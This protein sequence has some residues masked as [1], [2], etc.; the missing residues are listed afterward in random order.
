M[1]LLQP[2]YVS[3]RKVYISCRGEDSYI[4]ADVLIWDGQENEDSFK[5]GIYEFPFNFTIPER[6]PPSFE[7]DHGKIQFFCKA[8]V[9]RPW[10]IDNKAEI[11]FIVK[12]QFDLN[13]IPGLGNKVVGAI[14]E[15]LG[16]IFFK[17][18]KVDAK[19]KIC[20]TSGPKLGLVSK[21]LAPWDHGFMGTARVWISSGTTEACPTH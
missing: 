4:N 16:A 17:H 7:G 19:V 11:R 14:D 2:G 1:G 12:P 9:D 5:P 20:L 3:I 10:H 15:N 21:K 18:G 6:C 8:V 13:H